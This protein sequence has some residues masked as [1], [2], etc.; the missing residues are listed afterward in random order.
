MILLPRASPLV[1]SVVDLVPDDFTSNYNRR[2]KSGKD[3]NTKR[4]S[5]L[6]CKKTSLRTGN[7]SLQLVHERVVSYD[8]DYSEIDE[9]ARRTWQ[10]GKSLGLSADN[11]EDIID[12]LAARHMEKEE[13][14]KHARAKSK[15]VRQRKIKS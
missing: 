10:L 9:E 14:T 8:L 12:A 2:I 5:N 11:D 3:G 7:R 6:S 15:E 13:G 1:N 4:N